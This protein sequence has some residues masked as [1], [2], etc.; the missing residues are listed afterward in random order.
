METV[1]FVV[2]GDFLNSTYVQS[3]GNDSSGNFIGFPL[4]SGYRVARPS[5]Y[6][7]WIQRA[8]SLLGFVGN[9][10]A[11]AV[12]LRGRSIRKNASYVLLFNQSLTDFLSCF[13]V[14][15]SPLAQH[16]S[17]AGKSGKNGPVDYA[18]CV[19]INSQAPLKINAVV[20]TFNLTM[21]A[22][23]RMLCVLFPIFH[24]VHA[25]DFK[26]RLAALLV[27]PAV[28]CAVIPFVI[29]DNGIDASGRCR[30]NDRMKDRWWFDVS[31]EVLGLYLP[32]T[33]I[34]V[35]YSV[36]LQRLRKSRLSAKKRLSDVL[37]TLVTVVVVY[38]LCS[39]LRS[40]L[41]VMSAFRVDLGPGGVSLF[42]VAYSM[43]IASY[44]VNPFIYTLQYADY[45][46]ELERL[47]GFRTNK[48]NSNI[49]SKT[50]SSNHGKF[51]FYYKYV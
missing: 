7:E 4:H 43:K 27:W 11:M 46:T 48:I 44:C 39:A 36:I 9:L 49:F 40:V 23:E 5:D 34:V 42:T 14:L 38:V 2:T 25:T 10:I 22:V 12:V 41:A 50:C 3:F 37:K 47:F 18:V 28:F 31:F 35:C 24:R 13:Y 30:F 29:A 32:L 33:T 26:Q 51:V 45:R 8:V 1:E 17:G 16:V 19:M 15:I 6:V 21:L 20:S